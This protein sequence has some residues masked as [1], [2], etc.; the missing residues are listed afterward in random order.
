VPRALAMSLI[1]GD[2]ICGPP[3]RFQDYLPSHALA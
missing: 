3:W 1:L 2:F